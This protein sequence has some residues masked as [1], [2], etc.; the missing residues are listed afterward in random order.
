MEDPIV[1]VPVVEDPV[2]KVP[3]DEDPAVEVLVVEDPVVEAN[4]VVEDPVV[5][6][7]VIEEIEN[8]D[9]SHNNASALITPSQHV[10][11]KHDWTSSIDE[12]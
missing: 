7:P 9:G 5:E 10:V 3:V 1:E 12:I 6:D 11:F 8:K 2:V 4:P